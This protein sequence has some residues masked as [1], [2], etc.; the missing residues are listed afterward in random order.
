VSDEL[1]IKIIIIIN[2]IIIFEGKNQQQQQQID[3]S[4]SVDVWRDDDDEVIKVIM[5]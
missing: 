3:R 1:L 5:I 2:Y 4:T